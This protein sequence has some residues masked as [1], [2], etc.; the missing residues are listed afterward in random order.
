M[1]SDGNQRSI[2][3]V[4]LGCGLK[5]VG[6]RV[7]VEMSGAYRGGGAP[8]RA[9]PPRRKNLKIIFFL[10]LKILNFKKMYIYHNIIHQL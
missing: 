6:V 8:E 2:E 5:R 7:W 9:L 4:D 3:G 10:N 1:G